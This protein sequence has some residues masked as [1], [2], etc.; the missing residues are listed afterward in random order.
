MIF[1]SHEEVP[2]TK[3]YAGRGRYNNDKTVSGAKIK[4]RSIIF[5][6]RDQEMQAEIYQREHPQKDAEV[7]TTPKRIIDISE[8]RILLEE[9]GEKNV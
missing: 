8:L 7:E 1:F 5:G 3:S 9:E 2:D 6:E 4:D